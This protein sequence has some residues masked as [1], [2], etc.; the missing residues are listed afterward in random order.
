[1]TTP[2]NRPAPTVWF[3]GLSAAGK[4]TIG[5]G[6]LE[7]LRAEGRQAEMLDGDEVRK[8]L[9]KDLGFSRQDRDENIRRIGSLAGALHRQGIIA[10]VAVISPYRAVRDEVRAAIGEF[11]EVFVNAPLEVCEARDPKGLYRKA[12]AGEIRAFTGIDDPYEP[13]VNPEVECRTERESIEECVEKVLQA[14]DRVSVA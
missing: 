4:T 13:P 8:R 10:L 12:R 2:A 5:R 3:T 7:R 1:M 11:V 9:S 6:V 14:I